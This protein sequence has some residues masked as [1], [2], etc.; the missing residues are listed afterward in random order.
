MSEIVR[1]TAEH[2]KLERPEVTGKPGCRNVQR[3]RAIASAI[4]SRMGYSFPEM[5]HFFRGTRT[6]GH[7]TYVSA[8][9]R[10]EERYPEDIKAVMLKN[11]WLPGYVSMRRITGEKGPEFLAS[12]LSE[13]GDEVVSMAIEHV[14]SRIELDLANE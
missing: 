7:S 3:A 4:A 10:G 13:Y 9:K 5:S 6:R 11:D 14:A 12:L 2:C 8:A 1:A